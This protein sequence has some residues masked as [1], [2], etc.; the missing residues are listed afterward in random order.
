MESRAHQTQEAAEPCKG[1]PKPPGATPGAAHE[2]QKVGWHPAAWP[3]DI[4]H[5]P[6]ALREILPKEVD[7]VIVWSPTGSP[8]ET[9]RTQKSHPLSQPL[10]VCLDATEAT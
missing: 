4:L 5:R 6:A 7:L 1:L 2:S 8:E 10:N 3:S 9:V